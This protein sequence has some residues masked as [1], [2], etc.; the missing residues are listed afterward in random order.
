MLARSASTV[1]GAKPAGASCQGNRKNETGQKQKAT[2][3]FGF[4]FLL[5]HRHQPSSGIVSYFDPMV[6]IISKSK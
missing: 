4:F 5:L 3:L 6:K 1:V 2:V